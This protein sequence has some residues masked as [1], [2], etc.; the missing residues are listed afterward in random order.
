MDLL[1]SLFVSF[2]T[3]FIVMDP[4]ASIPP[5]LVFTKK[6]KD[7]ELNDTA[8][9]AVL[10]AGIIALIFIFGGMEILKILSVTLDDFKVAGGLVLVLMGLE[11]VLNFSLSKNEDSKAGLE[12]AVVLIATPLLTGPGLITALI[13]LVKDNGLVPV[14][15]SL[16][17]ALALSWLVLRNAVYLRNLCGDRVISVFSKI[18]SLLLMALGVSYIKTGL[19]G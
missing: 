16:F 17:A 3:I 7:K 8:N 15:A 18:M 6:C 19:V 11:N 12:S 9:K 10:I 4:F 13:I 5:F 1:T 14:L 2:F